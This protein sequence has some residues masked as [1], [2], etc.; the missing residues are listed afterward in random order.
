MT[1]KIIITTILIIIL[2][3]LFYIYVLPK[4]KINYEVSKLK[5]VTVNGKSI[6]TTGSIPSEDI[7]ANNKL[8]EMID[9]SR[10]K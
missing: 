9:S 10:P 6:K 2:P 8:K 4:L 3:I 7:E 1:K 5:S